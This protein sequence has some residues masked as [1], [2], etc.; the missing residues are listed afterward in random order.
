MANERPERERF[1]I[2]DLLELDKFTVTYDSM[3]KLKETIY[4]QV[5]QWEFKE[6]RMKTL[7]LDV[8]WAMD[9]YIPEFK[10]KLNA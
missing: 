8:E 9:C 2:F 5:D 4:S 7:E 6:Q 10:I 1:F 3:E